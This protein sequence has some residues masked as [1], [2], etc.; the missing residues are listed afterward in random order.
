[1]ASVPPRV[2]ALDTGLD[3]DQHPRVHRASAPTSHL[4][5]D[6]N[7][8]SFELPEN[9]GRLHVSLSWLPPRED[10]KP[11]SHS[12]PTAAT[13]DKRKESTP[14][15]LRRPLPSVLDELRSP[16]VYHGHPDM[17]ARAES[18]ASSLMSERHTMPGREPQNWH[19]D[20]HPYLPAP[21]GP[22]SSVPMPAAAPVFTLPTAIPM[23]PVM[24]VV[25]IQ[26]AHWG[27][28][29]APAG[30]PL[31]PY[32]NGSVVDL[33]QP[34]YAYMPV[35]SGQYLMPPMAGEAAGLSRRL[36]EAQRV[37]DREKAERRR[38]RTA[39][40]DERERREAE[41]N[42]LRSPETGGA[43]AKS[44]AEGGK[45]EAKS[46]GEG[47]RIEAKSGGGGGGSGKR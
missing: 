41:K 5:H 32:G 19:K 3:A 2:T 14:E 12:A 13:G 44:G 20:V 7:E 30:V 43:K 45:A 34:A 24:Q 26:Y 1:M 28:P 25:P 31:M 18:L 40:R 46:G 39:R 10:S 21:V 47:S 6:P 38:Q 22:M 4:E 9:R 17:R 42:T 27:F 29:A 16:N 36:S 8:I 11:K 35:P 15:P 33:T 37:Y 23:V